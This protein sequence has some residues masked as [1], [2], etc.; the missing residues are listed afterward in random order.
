[1]IVIDEQEIKECVES[2]IFQSPH[3]EA[4]AR[5]AKALGGDKTIPVISPRLTPHWAKDALYLL[6]SR[7]ESGYLL[8]DSCVFSDILHT[9]SKDSGPT[10]RLLVFQRVC[11]FAIKLWNHFAL[12]GPAEQWLS[13]GECGAVF[14]FPKSKSTGFRVTLKRGFD[15]SCASGERRS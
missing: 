8:F 10:N 4:G 6:H 14:P 5:L 7:T 11:R 3:F 2:N 12:S 15:I 9:T 1:M 13:N